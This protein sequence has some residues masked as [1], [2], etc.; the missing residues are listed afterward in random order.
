MKLV[1]A[2]G[3][4]DGQDRLHLYFGSELAKQLFRFCAAP[5][6]TEKRQVPINIITALVEGNQTSLDSFLVLSGILALFYMETGD[7]RRVALILTKYQDV[8]DTS[9]SNQPVLFSK[10]FWGLTCR[11]TYWPLRMLHCCGRSCTKHWVSTNARCTPWPNYVNLFP[12][13]LPPY[14]AKAPLNFCVRFS[15][16]KRAMC[17]RNTKF[18]VLQ[19]SNWLGICIAFWDSQKMRKRLQIKL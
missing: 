8:L 4:I 1:F 14:F 18:C 12:T 19:P 7:F 11:V 3:P 2:K 5:D 9:G 16:R 6:A 13:S 17:G 10:A 15:L